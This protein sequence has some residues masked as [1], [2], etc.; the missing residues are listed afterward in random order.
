MNVKTSLEMSKDISKPEQL[1][2]EHIDI[3]TS[4]ILAKSTSG[5]GSS[6]KY[7][8]YG[9]SKLRELI[10]ELA[11]RGKLVPQDANDESASVFLEKIAVE[12][13]NLIE[14][15]EDRKSVV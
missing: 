7:E 14:K 13:D 8:L 4:S 15:G 11:V 2:T 3:W 6:K 9:I 5:R 10:L 1:I 12:R